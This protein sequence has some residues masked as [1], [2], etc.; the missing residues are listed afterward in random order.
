MSKVLVIDGQLFQTPAWHR[1]MGKYSLELMAAVSKQEKTQLNIEVILSKKLPANKEML[2]QIKQKIPNAKI[3]FLNLR[4]NEIG[5]QKIVTHNRKVIDKF[6]GNK[7]ETLESID[8]LAL[9]LMQ[10]EIFPAFPSFQEVNKYVLFYDLIPLMFHNLYLK[11]RNTR[12]EY[13]AKIAE[14][15]HA[16]KYFTISKT[17]AND[18]SIYLGIDPSRIV[19]IDGGPI[20][21]S[22]KVELIDVPKPFILMPTGNDLRKNNR[23]AITGFDDFNNMH[24]G[25]Y[26]LVIT[27]FF[28]KH[29]IKELQ[30]LSDKVHFTGNVSGPQLSY[31]YKECEALL[32]PSEYEGLGLPILE[33]IEYNKPVACSDIAVFQEMS[34]DAFEYF[35]PTMPGGITHA[36]SELFSTQQTHAKEYKEILDKY[37]WASTANKFLVGLNEIIHQQPKATPKKQLDIL[38]QNPASE[39]LSARFAQ[40]SH[41][42]VSRLFHTNYFLSSGQ[43]S[44]K[45]VNYLPYIAD[46]HFVKDYSSMADKATAKVYYLS[47]TSDE[48]ETLLSALAVPG[49]VILYEAALDKV[50][51]SMLERALVDQSRYTLEQEINKE[52]GVA[53]TF[54][55]SLIANQRAIIVFTKDDENTIEKIAKK[56]NNPPKIFR[57]EMPIASLVYSE[58]RAQKSMKIGEIRE[59][60][61]MGDGRPLA[62]GTDYEFDEAIARMEFAVLE[63]PVDPYHVLSCLRFDT[64]PVAPGSDRSNPKSVISFDPNKQQP[65]EAINDYI[66]RGGSNLEKTKP[67][68]Y[69]E[70]ATQLRKVIDEVYE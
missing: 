49:T 45:R 51:K 62:H 41:A 25:K 60:S 17:V 39:N 1:G 27:S 2:S 9:S 59:N 22:E 20:D 40:D 15:L 31:L 11:G 68:S 26:S 6:L 5:N 56:L 66:S 61:I 7:D 28:N 33:A 21:H 53:N 48:A 64:L 44:S 70:F 16:D 57:L 54:L 3:N 34:P 55:A 43:D 37:T 19:N 14:L 24:D 18:L 36:L 46:A 69:Q 8:Y 47:N 52:I 65:N 30:K 4:P 35:E 58:A 13:L 10:G 50:W 12:R 32:F 38:M 67:P 63:K 23:R 29:E 42:E